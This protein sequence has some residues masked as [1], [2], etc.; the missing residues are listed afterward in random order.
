[1]AP[2]KLGN[3]GEGQH[4]LGCGKVKKSESRDR[5]G[6]PPFPT[7]RSTAAIDGCLLGHALRTVS[8]AAYMFW[9]V[10]VDDKAR[11]PAGPRARLPT[12]T[13]DN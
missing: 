9:M 5:A 4:T 13:C 3:E 11:T 7:A 2:G 1:M 12:R 10:A 8:V 6:R